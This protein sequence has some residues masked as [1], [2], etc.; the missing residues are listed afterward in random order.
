[1]RWS[2]STSV[3]TRSKHTCVCRRVRAMRCAGWRGPKTVIQNLHFGRN[4]R[5]DERAPARLRM[6][7]SMPVM[8]VTAPLRTSASRSRAKTPVHCAERE[9]AVRKIC[10][11]SQGAFEGARNVQYGRAS[12]GCRR[13]RR[14]P[15]QA[16]AAQ[17]RPRQGSG[18]GR[19]ACQIGNL[20]SSTSP[21][22]RIVAAWRA[23]AVAHGASERHPRNQR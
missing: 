3:V 6:A 19:A 4:R 10:G 13:V 2:F 20:A 22:G 9:R 14:P 17:P 12:P 15:V 21:K 7:A 18:R 5:D 23:P 8:T 1:M 16:I 11:S